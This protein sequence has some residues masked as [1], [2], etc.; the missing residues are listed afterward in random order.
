[1]S[2]AESDSPRE[3]CGVV[4][5]AAPE[6]DVS[7]LAYFALHAMQH[8]GQE[9]AGIAVADDEGVTVQR[10]LG[11]VTAVFDEPSLRG[12]TG[13][14]AIGHVRYSTTGA[15]KWD[16]AQ[17]LARPREGD[18]VTLG[19][20][21]NLTNSA[22]LRDELTA[23]GEAFDATS[24][25]ELIAAL[26][27]SEPGSLFAA[28]GAIMPRISG[29]YSVVAMSRDEVIAFR[30][31]HGIRPLVIGQ[32][33]GG[34]CAASETCALEQIGG[35]FVREVEPGEVVRIGPAAVESVQAE[36]TASRSLCVFEHIYFARPDS[37]LD[38]RAVWESRREM[39]AVLAGESAPEADLVMGLPDSGTPAAIGFAGESGIDYAEGVVR[40]RYVGR[41]FIQPDQDLR[42]QGVRLKFN[43]L[44][45][46]IRG[47]RIVVVDDSIVRGTTMSQIVQMLREAGAAE[48]HLRI[49]SPPILWP[50]FYGIDMATRD[51]LMAAN[52][53]ITQMAE[54]FGASSLA[55]LSLEGLQT[56]LGR[57][58]GNYCR[59][60]LTGEYPV[61]PPENGVTASACGT[62]EDDSPRAGNG[63]P[64]RS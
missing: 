46:V 16:N 42:R 54:D 36:K 35:E 64:V 8:R 13:H 5:I 57:P 27:A 1:M 63:E 26:L 37:V 32:L 51:Q 14:A 20:N 19:H 9:S 10:D 12:L 6:L 33:D 34:M 29:A 50:C 43:P 31:P 15:N 30:D 41:S 17:P 55:Y 2:G 24:D 60:C 39:G 3:E 23:E 18:I 48:V 52:R 56:A 40:N 53:S 45:G 58:A 61:A 22:E 21:G 44:P 47:K 62:V 7:R 38:D 4:A 11:L 25:S 59:A 49:S 28:A